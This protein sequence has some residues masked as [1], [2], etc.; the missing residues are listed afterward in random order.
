VWILFID[1]KRGLKSLIFLS[2]YNERK[3]VSVAGVYYR[4]EL[5]IKYPKVERRQNDYSKNS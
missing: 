3:E 4:Y 1:T 5:K 2:N